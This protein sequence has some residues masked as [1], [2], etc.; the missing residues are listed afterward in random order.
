MGESRFVVGSYATATAPG[1]HLYSSESGMGAI[2][3]LA[4]HAGVDHPSFVV[5]HP[6][7]AH[8]YAVSETSDPA[9]GT[10]GSVHAL[11]IV[12]GPR[13]TEFE[14]LNRL[15]TQGDHPCHLSIDPEGRW[16]VA[17]NY[18]G[19]SVSV[20]SLRPDGLLGTLVSHMR[21]TG[22]GPDSS[23]QREPHPH[24][25][26]FTPDGRFVLVADL[27][28]DVIATYSLDERS[29]ALSQLATTAAAPGSGPRLLAMHPD[30]AHVLVVNE[31]ANTLATHR[32]VDGRPTLVS[33][34]TTLSPEV[35]PGLAA[36]LAIDR[37][38]GRV[39]V[40]NRGPDTVSVFACGDGGTLELIDVAPCDGHWPR[41]LALSDDGSHLL[42]ANRRS[43]HISLLP[44]DR[45]GTPTGG[46]ARR[47]TLPE[48]SSIEF[49]TP[50]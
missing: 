29:G 40:S 44:L 8:C 46:P 10:G 5:T 43:G 13:T 24:S 3:L 38:G 25:S 35:A 15:S 32:L 7:G 31:L 28:A 9:G 6:D 33:V 14:P 19:G 16:L 42:I 48:P 23:R 47:L 27:G 2:Q 21:H 36:G 11:R 30:G 34:A 41:A 20:F 4:S 1:I 22:S 12:N 37:E 49:S 26:V 45:D 18:T 50:G 39:Y 17:S